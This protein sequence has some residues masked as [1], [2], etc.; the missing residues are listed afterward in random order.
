MASI[1]LTFFVGLTS[2]GMFAGPIGSSGYYAIKDTDDLKK[3]I[4]QMRESKKDL[5][6]LL[7]NDKTLENLYKL[8]AKT[9]KAYFDSITR[10]MNTQQDLEKVF[11]QFN[12]KLRKIQLIGIVLI[13]VIFFLL[14]LKQ[15]ELLGTV[16][17]ILFYPIIFIYEKLTG[18]KIKI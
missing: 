5:E 17:Y 4:S 18:N 12:T 8:N 13:V 3:S 1:L 2:L 16:Q 9:Q 7:K 15:F 11:T 6:E 14:L 10:Y